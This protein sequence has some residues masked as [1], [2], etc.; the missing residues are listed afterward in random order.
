[1]GDSGDLNGRML[2]TTGAVSLLNCKSFIPLPSFS[3]TLAYEDLWPGKGDFDFNDM[4]V[5]YEFN[6]VKNNQEVVQNITATFVLKAFG[7]SLHNGFGFTLPT[8][9]PGD[10]VSVSGYDAANNSIFSIANNGLENGQSKATIIVF[11]AT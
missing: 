4:V 10:I 1:M 3:G 2:P 7:A 6:I 5:D 11:D 8:V 9:N